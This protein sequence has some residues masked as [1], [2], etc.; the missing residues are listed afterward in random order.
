MPWVG[1]SRTPIRVVPSYSSSTILSNEED[2]VPRVA[3]SMAISS[4]PTASD[5]T[6][7]FW[8]NAPE[9]E[10]SVVTLEL[11]HSDEVETEVLDQFV[12]VAYVPLNSGLL[13]TS[14]Q[15]PPKRQYMIGAHVEWVVVWCAA[16]GRAMEK[17]ETITASIRCCS[18]T[19]MSDLLLLY[20]QLWVPTGLPS[21]YPTQHR[22][23]A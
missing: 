12:Q 10:V 11:K 17:A 2:G 5:G 4:A 16:A 18:F 19:F 7:K 8:V 23:D 22:T 15:H 3:N 6:E 21:P 1:I 20:S 13:S 14:Y 9:V